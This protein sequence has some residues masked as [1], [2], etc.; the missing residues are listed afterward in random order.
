LKAL[1]HHGGTPSVLHP[2]G[3]GLVYEWRGDEHGKISI[4]GPGR[5]F[6]I[7]EVLELVVSHC[8]PTVNLFDFFYVTRGGT[9]VDVW[10]IDLRGKGQ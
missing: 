10:P 5:K 1:Y 9:V 2:D 6:E 8:D 4:P 7:G 3:L